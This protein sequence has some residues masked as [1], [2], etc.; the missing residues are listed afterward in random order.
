MQLIWGFCFSLSSTCSFR[1]A[2]KGEPDGEAPGTCRKCNGPRSVDDQRD[3]CVVGPRRLPGWMHER[4]GRSPTDLRRCPKAAA[5][6]GQLI[7][8]RRWLPAPRS[9]DLQ[10]RPLMSCLPIT[11][12]KRR[13]RRIVTTSK[14]TAA[15][16]HRAANVESGRLLD[17]LVRCLKRRRQRISLAALS[18]LVLRDIGLTRADVAIEAD[19]PFWQP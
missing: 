10:L 4:E 6:H 17:W 14:D 18:D 11:V 3:G 7:A 9:T 12:G 13:D 2:K 19:K 5:G 1:R 16:R 15:G 8:K